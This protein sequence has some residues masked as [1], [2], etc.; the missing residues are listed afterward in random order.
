MVRKAAFP[1]RAYDLQ[2]SCVLGGW[3][4]VGCRHSSWGENAGP[5]REAGS[6]AGGQREAGVAA[7]RLPGFEMERRTRFLPRTLGRLRATEGNPRFNGKNSRIYK[8][9]FRNKSEIILEFC[10]SP[11]YPEAYARA[12]TGTV[13]F[14]EATW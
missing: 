14:E 2:G 9:P 11:L 10:R 13:C 12:A 5:L 8:K 6:Q 1:A 4:R 7:P 3:P